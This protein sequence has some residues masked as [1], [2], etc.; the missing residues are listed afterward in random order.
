ML[1]ENEDA[2]LKTVD[3][4]LFTDR[5]TDTHTDT[6]TDMTNYMIV[7]HPQMGNYKKFGGWTVI[8]T[9]AL[10]TASAP[11]ETLQTLTSQGQTLVQLQPFSRNF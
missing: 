8:R 3:S 1:T 11:N 9:H 7:A 5:H 2:A 10:G 6:Q 4:T